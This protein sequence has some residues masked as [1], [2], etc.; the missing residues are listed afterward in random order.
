M[1]LTA[2]QT[3]AYRAVTEAVA[4]QQRLLLWWS[5]GVRSGKSY[6]TT[7]C[8]LEHQRN[9]INAL[10]LILAY[11]QSQALKI[12]GKY[13]QTI[14]EDMGF[15]VKVT[16]GNQ[17]SITVW[18]DGSPYK[19]GKEGGNV[20]M[21]K[22]ADSTG[23]DRNIQGLTCDGLLA[24]ELPLLNREAVHQ[25]EARVSATG[26]LRIY[27]SNKTSEYHWTVKYYINRIKEGS[28]QGKIIDSPISENPHID[29]D[30]ISERCSEYTGNTL[31]R[32]MENQ[33]TLDGR[34]IYNVKIREDLSDNDLTGKLY[35]SIYGHPNGYEIVKAYQVGQTIHLVDVWSLA[36]SENL[37]RFLKEQAGGKKPS[38]VMVNR[39]QSVLARWLRALQWPV[40]G[41]FGPNDARV[42]ELLLKATGEGLV[43]MDVRSMALIEAVRT[44]HKPGVYDFACIVAVEALGFLLRSHLLTHAA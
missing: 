24:D 16:G 40:T 36:V 7:L 8:F 44:H 13:F 2:G 27:T 10:Y 14:G 21:I 33:F 25:A 32:F 9:R 12:F 1:D 20:F 37:I 26:G 5:G 34:A 23:R 39:S 38:R 42:Q 17:P 6:G 30:Y 18:P 4:K 43:S 19:K 31:T 22:G 29:Q 3:Q 41:Y 35:F 11:T 28:I 15:T